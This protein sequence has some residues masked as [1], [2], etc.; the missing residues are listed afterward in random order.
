MTGDFSPYVLFR[1]GAFGLPALR[2][3]VPERFWALLDEAEE[4]ARRRAPLRQKLADALYA[5]VPLSA[6]EYRRELLAIRR[7]VHND[8]MPPSPSCPDLLSDP[9]RGLLDEWRAER[10]I[11]EGL[12]ARTEEVLAAELSAGRQALA[13]VARGED[14]QRGVQLSGEDVYRE[15]MAY[16]GNPLEARRKASRTRRAESTV[17]SFAYRVA[18]KPSPFGAFTEIGAGPWAPVPTTAVRRTQVRLSVGLVMWML[19]QLHR[20]DGADALLRVRLNN[21]LRVQDGRAVFVRRPIEGSEDGFEP[22]KVVVARH[23]D[24]VRALTTILGAG[25]LTVTELCDRLVA[26]GLPAASVRDTVEK[27]IRLGLCH[28]GLGLPDQTTDLAGEAAVRLRRLGTPQA[29][30]CAEILEGLRAIERTYGAASARRRTDLLAQLRTLVHRFAEVCSGP[31]P[32]PEAMRAAL[33]EDVGTTGRPNTWRPQILAANCDNLDLLQRLVPVLDDATIEK[34]GL[35][36]FFVQQFGSTA[37]VPLVEVYRRFAELPPAAASAVMCG[38]DDPTS[39]TVHRLRE[40]FFGLLRSR[41]AADPAAERLVLAPAELAAF[42]DRLPPSV[43]PWRSAAYRVQ[44][45]VETGTAV[46]NGMTT[47][48]GVFFS[49]FCELLEPEDSDGWS[50]ATVLRRHVARTA[51]RQTDLTVVLGLNFN[52]HPRLSP[53]E[54]VYPGSVAAPGGAAPLTVGD[55]SVRADRQRHRLVLVSDRDG[56]PIDLVPLNFLYPA[57]APMLYRFLCVFAPT[58]T[59]RGGLWDQL[60]RADGPYVGPRPRLLLGD[61]VLDRRSWR[62][63]I[64]DLPA[65]AQL[66][67]YESSGL[68]DFDSWRRSVGLPRQVFF[69]LVP[70]RAVPHGERDLLAETRQWALEARSARLHK[71]HYLDTRNPF[72]AHVFA[73]QARAIRGGSVVLHECLPQTA[74]QDGAGGAEEFFV[75]F[76]RRVT[77]V[78]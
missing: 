37:Q 18:L 60:D 64:D 19:H 66:E 15:V 72:L 10:G 5:A 16:A 71:P 47:G 61:L 45:D 52:L 42:V 69:R 11:A 30:A 53:M 34:L 32:T 62:F 70:P 75:E 21:S 25:D 46:V 51:P 44:F 76:N 23:T 67:R 43:A 24:L 36:G 55:L 48:R 1:R 3:L 58:R 20:I 41:L 6:T 35:Y 65:L 78:G 50:L 22:D 2:G 14:F 49:R 28:R 33:Y 4:T 40:D 54:L 7:A 9:L 8:R 27:L 63:D 17:T 56:Q 29:A 59:Y 57:A 38:V 26:V 74:D 77:D 13:E 31:P 73:K 39:A 12:A 68:A